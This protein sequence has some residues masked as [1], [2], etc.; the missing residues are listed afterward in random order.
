VAAEAGGPARRTDRCPIQSLVPGRASGQSFPNRSLRESKFSE[1]FGRGLALRRFAPPPGPLGTDRIV[2][3]YWVWARSW[4]GLS[5]GLVWGSIFFAVVPGGLWVLGSPKPTFLLLGFGFACRELFG[6]VV[7]FEVPRVPLADHFRIDVLL[8]HVD[9]A[10]QTFEVVFLLPSHADGVIREHDA[11]GVGRFFSVGL[12]GLG[13]VGPLDLDFV[14]FAVL[15]FGLDRVP[16]DDFR[17]DGIDGFLFG[18]GGS[19]FG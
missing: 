15:V 13:G 4:S 9:L 17:D 5:I 6:L 2:R 11:E 10:K 1:A 16:I 19:S 14:F 7:A 3:G 12:L 18:L 8:A